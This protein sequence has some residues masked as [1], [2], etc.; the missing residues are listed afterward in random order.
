MEFRR[1]MRA[2]VVGT[3]KRMPVTCVA[4]VV[5]PRV[6]K[7]VRTQAWKALTAWVSGI[8]RFSREAA[9][10]RQERRGNLEPFRGGALAILPPTVARQAHG[11]ILGHRRD[12]R[13]DAFVE[14]LLPGER[15]RVDRHE[16]LPDARG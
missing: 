1:G 13:L 2:G 8:G 4:V 15:T 11:G 7:D 9:N 6:A 14:D 12:E 3:R 16:R 5:I 10:A